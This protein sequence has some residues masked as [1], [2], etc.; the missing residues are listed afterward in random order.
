MCCVSQEHYYCFGGHVK[1]LMI[2]RY[3]WC[4]H[5]EIQVSTEQRWQT[6][7]L[8]FPSENLVR[9]SAFTLIHFPFHTLSLVLLLLL[10]S[11]QSSSASSPGYSNRASSRS[12]ISL[13]TGPWVSASDDSAYETY[14]LRGAF[15]FTK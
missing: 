1:E 9:V 10:F 11:L 6:S 7:F 14:I 8:C 4:S 12:R 5:D 2:V 15:S 3:E 13:W